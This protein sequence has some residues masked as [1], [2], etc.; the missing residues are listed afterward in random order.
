MIGQ[1]ATATLWKVLFRFRKRT[2]NDTWVFQ[3]GQRLVLTAD[4]T[5]AD[6]LDVVRLLELGPKPHDGHEFSF[7]ETH[8]IEDI[9]GLCQ[10]VSNDYAWTAGTSAIEEL[11]KTTS[12]LAQL[13]T[14]NEGL[15]RIAKLAWAL[16]TTADPDLPGALDEA[17]DFFSKVAM[18]ARFERLPQGQVP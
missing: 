8:R 10:L 17:L 18:P 4:P 11:A 15:Y 5:G 12:E 7:T 2:D 14:E 1:R 6:L 13:R 3:H 9:G 16:R